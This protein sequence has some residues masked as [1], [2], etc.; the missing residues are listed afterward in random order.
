MCVR[1]KERAAER[2]GGTRWLLPERQPRQD[3]SVL[4]NHLRD[5][6]YL[7]AGSPFKASA[8]LGSLLQKET[9][10]WLIPGEKRKLYLWMCGSFNDQFKYT[11]SLFS[12]YILQVGSVIQ[13]KILFI[14]VG[15]GGTK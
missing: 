9:L 6:Y 4:V 8:S 12:W 13:T 1:E 11:K 15:R 3:I 2:D 14:H 10:V 7:M 5:I